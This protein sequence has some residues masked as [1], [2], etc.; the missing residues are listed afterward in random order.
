MT[1]HS[2][3]V[4]GCGMKSAETRKMYDVTVAGLGPAGLSE[5]VYFP[6]AHL[7]VIAIGPE[8]GA[9]INNTPERNAEARSVPG[10]LRRETDGADGKV[11][12]PNSLKKE[13]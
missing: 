12:V 5:L 4:K 6:E 9:Q 11:A 2:K 7:N 13:G 8:I 3:F 10:S 1:S